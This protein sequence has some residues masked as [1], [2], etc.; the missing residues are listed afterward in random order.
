MN[1]LSKSG[2]LR[3]TISC[4]QLGLNLRIYHEISRR[5]ISMRNRMHS[6]DTESGEDEDDFQC[7]LRDVGRQ[8]TC[9][10]G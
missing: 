4:P 3:R 1:E 6:S 10:I 7:S 9:F 5:A 8:V 2:Q